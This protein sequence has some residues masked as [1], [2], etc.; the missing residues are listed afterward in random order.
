MYVRFGKRLLD[1]A[2]AGTALI[3]FSPAIAL[4]ALLVR[5]RLGSPVLFTQVRPGKD[6]LPFRMIKFRTMTDARDASGQL[7]PDDVRLTRFG[8]LLRSTSL[9]ELPELWNVVRGEMSLVGPRPLLMQYLPLYSEDQRRRHNVLP[10][11]TGWA[12]VNGRNR[13]TWEE[14]FAQD[15]WYV[16]HASLAVDLRILVLTVLKV[17]RRDGVAAEGHA[18]MPAFLGNSAEQRRAA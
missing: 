7:L 4:V 3:V 2:L 12:Q 15:T 8:R 17:V 6:G 18:T 5:T 11:L 16:D 10:G 14:R 9:D 1:L 13:T